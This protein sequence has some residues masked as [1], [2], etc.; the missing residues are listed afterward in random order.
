M[1]QRSPSL[2]VLAGPLLL[3]GLAFPALPLEAAQ[4]QAAQAVQAQAA[5]AQA[6]Q[7]RPAVTV[8]AASGRAEVQDAAGRWVPLGQTRVVGTTLRT[9]AGRVT[10]KSGAGQITLGSASR[11]RVY[12]QEPDLQEGQFFFAGSGSFY[13]LGWHLNVQGGQVR[14]DLLPGSPRPRVAVIAGRVRLSSGSRTVQLGAGEQLSLRSGPPAAFTETDPWYRAQFVGPGAATIEALRG[15]VEYRSGEKVRGATMGQVLGTGDRVSTGSGAWAEIGFSGGGYLRLTEQSELGVLAVDKTARGREVTLRLLRGSAWSVVQKGQGGYRITTPVVSTAVRGTTFRVDAAG[16][17]KVFEGQ[18]ELP[19][20]PAALVQAGQ[21][22]P[23]GGEVRPLVPDALD[24][25][26]L[27]LDRERAAPLHAQFSLPG[28]AA[29]PWAEQ[30]PDLRVSAPQGSEV[31]ARLVEARMGE[32][33]LRLDESGAGVFTLP[34]SLPPLP[35]G[36]YDVTLSA[37]RAGQLW[38]RRFPLV[39]D[40]TVPVLEG[41]Q[42]RTLGRLLL[43]SGEV[44]DGPASADSR[45][46]LRIEGAGTPQMRTLRPGP[47]RVLLPAPTVPGELRLSVRDAAGNE[48]HV[49]LP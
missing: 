30:A 38:Q 2:R 27:A 20:E 16:L 13:A 9:G 23:A 22:K 10:L 41:V 43:L 26:N 14:A 4:A 15:A 8:A 11:L 49:T 7:A 31:E 37:R 6:V 1:S 46:Q 24:Q 36:R 48:S 42:R 21:E 40:R 28:A 34:A 39:L 35:D 45:L 29:R 3:V 12:D 18:V 25:F 44:R 5:Q 33:T 32:Q 17:V 47:F 19:S